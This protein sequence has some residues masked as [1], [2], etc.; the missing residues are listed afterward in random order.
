MGDVVP[1]AA[2]AWWGLYTVGRLADRQSITVTLRGEPGRGLTAELVIPPDLLVGAATGWTATS[3]PAGAPFA[4]DLS[5][6]AE[7]A[8]VEAT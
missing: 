7:L 6:T 8:P 2:G 5:A 4:V 3:A 1:P